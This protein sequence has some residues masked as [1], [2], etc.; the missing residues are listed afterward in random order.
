MGNSDSL[1][2]SPA[3]SSASLRFSSRR[4]ELPS[5]RSWWRSQGV[6]GRKGRTNTPQN[7]FIPNKTFPP[8]NTV[9]PKNS[10]TPNNTFTPNITFTPPPCT[11]WS[12]QSGAASPERR[13]AGLFSGGSNGAGGGGGSPKVLLTK[14]GSNNSSLS[15][16]GSWF[17]SPWGGELTDNPPSTTFSSGDS[18][19][20]DSLILIPV[21]KTLKPPWPPVDP[22]I[23]H[24]LLTPPPSPPRWMPLL[25]PPPPLRQRWCCSVTPPP[26]AAAPGN[27]R[28]DF[29]K[30]VRRLSDWTGSLTRKKRR[31]QE[32]Y[33]SSEGLT[34]PDSGLWICNPL[35][36]LNQNQEQ[37]QVPVFPCRSLNQNQEQNQVSVFPC[38]S[39]N[40]NQ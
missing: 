2:V 20:G 19:L 27:S 6:S 25:L 13:H 4:E 12:Y 10:F 28:K 32:P 40:Q 33:G 24:L 9:T 36:A 7:T 37:N 3:V 5:A 14:D 38:R 15:S 1:V 8:N 35:H 29:L 17:D 22:Q 39:L 34:G 16:D 30:S 26:P 18:G 21:L 11:S 23:S 31:V